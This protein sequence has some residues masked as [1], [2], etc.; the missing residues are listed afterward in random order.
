[1]K[2]SEIK[3]R[4]ANPGEGC[5]YDKRYAICNEFG[6]IAFVHAD[7]EQDAIDEAVDRGKLD[8][9]RMTEQEYTDY[10]ANGWDDSYIL[11]GNAS[12]PFWCEYM[13]IREI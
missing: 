1:M 9:E 4:I 3:R 8:S 12:E 13:S 10:Q 11:A 7:C 2:Y 5:F 6:P